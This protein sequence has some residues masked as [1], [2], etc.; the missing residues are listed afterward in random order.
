MKVLR[1]ILH[2]IMDVIAPATCPVCHKPLDSK[3][4][5]M[6]LPCLGN[7]PRALLHKQPYWDIQRI[8]D[9]GV[10]PAGLCAA[11]FI[12]SPDNPYA[13]LIR[14]AKYHDMPM[15][16]M[17]LGRMFAMELMA[18]SPAFRDIDVLLPV[19]M[20]WF[21][22]LRRGFNQAEMIA[23]GM[24]KASGIPVGDNLYATRRHRSQTH[25]K[26]DERLHNLVGSM[27]VRFPDELEGLNIALVDDVITT[28][29]TLAECV[30]AISRSGARPASIGALFLGQRF[31]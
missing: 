14:D 22:N 27:G 5:P 17:E 2:E 21:K 18:D 3:E 30:G 8:L 7:L 15:M 31:G 10:A 24:S 28:G 25:F 6:C 9:N 13:N 29:S 23:K 11:W 26:R 16:A 1:N 4:Y 12:Y 20:F 19:P